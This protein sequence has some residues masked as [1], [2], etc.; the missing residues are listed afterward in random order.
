MNRMMRSSAIYGG[1]LVVLLAASWWDYTAEP[2][3]EL[4]GKVVLVAGEVEDLTK[5]TWTS[6]N[7]D[8]AIIERQ[9]DALG[10]FYNVQYSRWT[11]VKTPEPL[12]P[13]T[14]PEPAEPEGPK[15]P[16]EAEVE[17][18]E[19]EAPEPEPEPE[20]EYDVS[21]SHFK[22]GDKGSELFESL[23]PLLALRKLDDM[24][25]E[26]IETTGLND[27]KD[28]LT[29]ERKGK[30][31]KLDV[32]GEVYGTRD[33]YVRNPEN[34]EVYL[35]DDEV[36]RPLRYART[37]L[38]DRSLWSFETKRITS[39]SIGSP[40]GSVDVSQKNAQD[41]E[42]ATWVRAD[43][44]DDA[45]EQ[46]KTWMGKALRMKSTA[47]ATED[48][49]I[50]AIELLF[51]LTFTD[52]TGQTQTLEIL[53]KPDDDKADYWGRSEHTRGVVKLLR[54]QTRQLAD[55]IDAIVGAAGTDDE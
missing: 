37:R 31:I 11:E 26:K 12:T 48:A 29:L 8:E 45:D 9:E 27:P 51:S 33:R 14:P 4:D 3:L 39:V 5:V 52:D 2:A 34:N 15:T 55:D 43:A 20:P 18:P 47:Y 53:R 21:V 13:P 22:A 23:A 24:T 6:R 10:T 44:P 35:V 19:A 28:T 32:G 41:P 46:L 40:A 30:T 25:D 1:L 50:D 16:E 49:D 38:P 42:K 36:L 17:A 7:K 54:G